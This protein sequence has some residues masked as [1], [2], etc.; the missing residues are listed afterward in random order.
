MARTAGLLPVAAVVAAWCLDAATPVSARGRADPP[1]SGEAAQ[2]LV[3]ESLKL[4]RLIDLTAEITGQ[5]FSYSAQELGA[6]TVTLRV[7]GG[8]TRDNLPLLLE[9]VLASRG[10]TTVRTPGSPVLSVVKIEQAAGLSS[11]AVSQQEGSV[12]LPGYVTELIE[13]HHQSAKALAEAVKLVLSKPGGAATV[14]GDSRLIAVSDLSSRVAEVKA[15]VARLDVQDEVVTREIALKNLPAAQVVALATQLIAKKDAAGGIKL[16][17]ELVPTPDGASVLLVCPPQSEAAWRELLQTVDRREPVETRSYVTRRIPA[18]DL[19]KPVETIGSIP[20]RAGLTDDR[21]RVVV[22]DLTGTLIVTATTGQHDRIADLL[23]RTDDQEIAPNPV[24]S[25]AIRNRPVS[26]VLATLQ[27]LV[28]AGILEGGTTALEPREAVREGASQSS[29]RTPFPPPTASPPLPG[30]AAGTLPA[31]ST[32]SGM[33]PQ[34][35]AP[36]S[37]VGA[38]SM[39]ADEATNTLIAIGEPRMLD[40]LDELLKTIDVR[41]PQVM[42]EVMLVSFSDTEALSFGVELER[43][44]SLNNASTQ[45]SSLFGLTGGSAGNRTVPDK[46]GF[47]G[48]VLNAGEFSLVVRAL[49]S[50][51]K[52][53]ALSNPKLLVTNNQRAVFSSTLQQPITQQTRTG[54][55]D[56]T[57]SYGGSESAGTTIS[58]QPQIAQGD[59]LSLTYSIKLSNFVGTS[60]TAGLPPPKQ[61]NSVDSSATIPD[62]HTVVVGGMELITNSQAIAQVPWIANIPLIGEL[63]KTRDLGKGRTRFYVFIRANVLRNGML[64]DLKYM[65]ARDLDRVNHDGVAVGDGFPVVHARVIR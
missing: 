15:L 32:E 14:L 65:S 26:D 42:L 41:Q 36:S 48:A 52:G 60:T 46:A 25:Y 64:E 37:T 47:T 23:R 57:F 8:L 10:F 30:P 45:L 5:A 54:S 24:R 55:N 3:S 12:V 22:D 39:T 4:A 11:A 9:H 34:R 58:V 63:F 44:G 62:G 21:F 6:I 56:T 2:L 53:N 29:Y 50:I 40:R 43:L 13:A 31:R 18:K 19:A 61:E 27:Q 59:H 38:L 7:P 35:R 17:G 28:N 16:E 49:E 51:N 33:S 1:P 20:T